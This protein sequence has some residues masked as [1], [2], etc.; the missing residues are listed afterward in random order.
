[1]KKI[2]LSA[3]PAVEWKSPKGKYRKTRQD[4]S[5]ALGREP[6]SLDLAKRHPFDLSIFRLPPGASLC[7]YHE[8]SAQWEMYIVISGAGSMR[9]PDG[10]T[11]LRKD[12]V[13]L[14]PAGEAHQITNTGAAELAFYIIA[15]N[16]IGES[17]HYPDS[18][19]FAVYRGPGEVIVDGSEANYYAGEE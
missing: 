4:I 10:S 12:D 1:M 15:D 17:C 8:H 6:E 3:V 7:P 18:G 2:N 13:I 11:A 14:V 16:P 9:G 5:V 19:K